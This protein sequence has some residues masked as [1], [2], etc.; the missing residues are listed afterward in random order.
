MVKARLSLQFFCSILL[1]NFCDIF[2]HNCVVPV[3]QIKEL[4]TYCL[5]L[6]SPVVCRF[7]NYEIKEFVLLLAFFLQ[8]FWGSGWTFSYDLKFNFVFGSSYCECF[9]A[10]VYC[11]EPCSCQGCFNKPIHEDVV[12]ATR[13]QIES[14]NALA[15]APKVIRTTDPAQEVG[16]RE[17][18]NK[19][20]KKVSNIIFLTLSDLTTIISKQVDSTQTPASAR[21]KRGCNCKKSNCL[22]KYCE[23][24]QVLHLSSSRLVF[25]LKIISRRLFFIVQGWCRMLHQLQMWGM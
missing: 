4:I 12:L 20:K 11:I 13:K 2:L 7:W 15:F 19:R 18:V 22:K 14:R 21:H 3:L 6:K 10:G 8:S 1:K 16:V 24:Y 17:E 23:C 25:I 9:A 5:T